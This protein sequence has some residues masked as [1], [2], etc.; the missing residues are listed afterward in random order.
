[1]NCVLCNVRIRKF[2]LNDNGDYIPKYK[3]EYLGYCCSSC[4]RISNKEYIRICNIVFK[5]RE[6]FIQEHIKIL[7]L[8]SNI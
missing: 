2:L 3:L 6:K 5:E 4:F 8:N 1:M 7:K